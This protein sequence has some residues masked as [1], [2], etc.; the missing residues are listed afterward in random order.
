M[1]HNPGRTCFLY[2]IAVALLGVV[3][4][5]ASQIPPLM[6]PLDDE[7]LPDDTALV[8]SS[9]DITAPLLFTAYESG[10]AY[11]FGYNDL[12][13][14]FSVE[15]GQRVQLNAS[16]VAPGMSTQLTVDGE[17]VL[18]RPNV[19]SQVSRFYFLP[20]HER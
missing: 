12:L 2:L 5:C 10:T 15:K 6:D 18:T 1:R 13:A 8:A 9:R 16:Q 14:T 3:A 7:V 11:Y 17:P 4:S 20:D 19:R